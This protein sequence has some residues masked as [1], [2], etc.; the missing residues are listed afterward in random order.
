LP[1]SDYA[2]SKVAAT[3]LLQFYGK[4]HEFPAWV[5]RLYSV[6]GP[7]EE[8]SRL[9]PRLLLKAAEGHLPELVSPRVSRDFIHVD[10]VCRA[11]ESVLTRASTLA[12]GE[13]YNIGTGECTTLEKLVELVRDLFGV[14]DNPRW[15][16]MPNRHWDHA[17]WYSNPAKA[18]RDLQWSPVVPLKDGISQTMSWMK[19][20]PDVVRQGIEHSVLR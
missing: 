13:V 7:Y 17:D 4:K 19:S 6:Y 12:R 2:V 16:S 8:T 15:G 9:I 18:K 11:A 3:S 5:F 10:D 14:N 1:D 20:N